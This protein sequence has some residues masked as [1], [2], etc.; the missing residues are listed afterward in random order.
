[1]ILKIVAKKT[2]FLFAAR[3]GV[4]PRRRIDMKTDR[5]MLAPI[6]DLRSTSPFC[7]GGSRGIFH[8]GDYLK[9]EAN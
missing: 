8:K 6:F 2:G 1:M 3:C 9:E 5:G 4:G 7:K